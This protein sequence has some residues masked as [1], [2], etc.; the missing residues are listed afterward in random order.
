MDEI[1]LVSDG[2]G[3]S[4]IGNRSAVERFLDEHGLL[5]LSKELGLNK[6]GNVLDTGA[7][8]AKA[9]S[10]IA[11]NSAR[12]LK[13]T[14]ESAEVIKKFG[15]TET[16]TPGISHAMAGSRGDIKSWIQVENGSGSFLTNPAL[17]L[18]AAGLM[19]QLA[20]QAEMSEIKTY[21]ANISVKVDDIIRAQ[22]D[23]EL[24]K[25][26]G[27]SLDI[28]SAM[29]VRDQTGKVDPTTWSTVQGRTQTITDTLGW[30][31]L[32]LDAV[33][34]KL[35][36]K[37]KI[38]GQATAATEAESEVRE[39]LAV[40]AQCF[41]LQDALDV[42][43][44]ERVMDDSPES[45][46][47]QRL[48]L[49][50]DRQQ[51]RDRIAK[52]TAQLMARMNAAA[53]TADSRVLLHLPKSRSVVGSVN[54]VG[55]AVDEFHRPLGISLAHDLLQGTEWWKA[56]RS[57]EHLKTAGKEVAIATGKGALAVGGA[58]VI[59]GLSY[60]AKNSRKDT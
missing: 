60:L 14:P 54:S 13:V 27:A 11:A 18:G 19:A 47:G 23:A 36:G 52:E 9:G 34:E 12:W 20:R 6:L 58:A 55:E 57:T 45:L 49:N 39:L 21:L 33:A 41:E 25:I 51:R 4:V 56:I 50:A 16:T 30:A 53:G 59:A 5:A 32:R 35:E 17:L 43:R 24:A 48:A 26:I 3:L 42:L 8:V 28:Q 1:E 22:K 2:D 44:L 29:A 15:L 38:G 40:I 31:L 37:T 7:K 46:E 10:E